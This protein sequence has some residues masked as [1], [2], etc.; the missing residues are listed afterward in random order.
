MSKE[1]FDN[2]FRLVNLTISMEYLLHDAIQELAG[3]QLVRTG[4]VRHH[5]LD[6]ARK[7]GIG[8]EAHEWLQTA[9]FA[10]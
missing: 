7:S 2:T 8:S 5:R 6:R 10:V 4:Y 1:M 3:G 9:L